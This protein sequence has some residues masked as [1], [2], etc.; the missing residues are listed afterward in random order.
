MVIAIPTGVKIF[1]WLAT[2]WGGR[3]RLDTPML[4]AIGFLVLFTIG[5]LTGVVM[6]SASLDI[7]IHDTYYIIAHFHYVLSMGAVFALIGGI[8]L[9]IG[10]ITGYKYKEELGRIHFWSLFIG[11]NLTFFVQHFLGLAGMPRRIPDYP[12]VYSSWNVISSLG[13]II[14]VVSTVVFF[15]AIYRVFVDKIE[16]GDNAW[17]ILPFFL[18]DNIK[19]KDNNIIIKVPV[20]T[21]EW[22]ETSPPSFHTNTELPL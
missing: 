7:A 8:Y 18:A 4:F 15:Y 3:I 16:A 20:T 2:L 5:G 21:L 14:S 19:E 13:S 10:K 12:D 1:S 17:E 9:W 11:V 22:Q 6:A